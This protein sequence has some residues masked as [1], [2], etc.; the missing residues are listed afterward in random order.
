MTSTR[1][2][3]HAAKTTL[4]RVIAGLEADGGEVLLCRAG[5][6]VAKITPAS[7]PAKR[8]GGQLKGQIWI[9]DDFDAPD[10]SLFGIKAK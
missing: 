8:S 5:K 6:P 1:I 10:G 4:S 3:I 7:A 9:S 2:N